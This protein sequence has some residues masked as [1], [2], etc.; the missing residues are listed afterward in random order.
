MILQKSTLQDRG[1]RKIDIDTEL[2][3]YMRVER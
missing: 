2:E 3:E 1:C